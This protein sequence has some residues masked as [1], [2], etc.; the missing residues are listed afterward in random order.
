[1]AASPKRREFV[2]RVAQGSALAASGGLLWSFVLQKS[3]QATPFAIR[4]PGALAEEDFNAACIKC[5][6]CVRAC[7]YDTLTLAKAEDDIPIGT[8]HFIPRETP[9]YMCEDIPCIKACPTG[10]LDHDVTDIN[11]TEMGLAVIDIESCLSWQG[12]RCEVC[13]REC[14]VK[15]VAISVEHY[16]RKLS[17]HGMVVPIMHADGCTGCGICE[18]A[19]PTEKAAITVVKADLVRGEIGEHYRLGWK[20]DSEITQD[21]KP[22]KSA[23][24]TEADG[25]V[26][27]LDYLNEGEL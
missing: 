10:A 23:P 19:C 8:P 14:P 24:T 16:P 13:Y 2:T 25:T 11:E 22:A 18:K 3:A 26:P 27:G 6:Q 9:C 12:L 21:F 5:G 1:M 17:K 7:P 15:D 4:P 20:F